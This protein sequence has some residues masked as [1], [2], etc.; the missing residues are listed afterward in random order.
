MKSLQADLDLINFLLE[1][2]IAV[3]Q[4]H[5]LLL[6]DH[7]FV[8]EISHTLVD[9]LQLI[10]FVDQH[11][12]FFDPLAVKLIATFFQII[13]FSKQVDELILIRVL[14]LIISLAH[15]FVMQLIEPAH[16]MLLFLI[17][18]VTLFDLY[19]VGDDEVLLVILLGQCLLSLFLKQFNLRLSVQLIN[20]DT[21]DFVQNIF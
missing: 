3:I 21:C 8:L 11:S 18:V 13:T 2:S 6:H 1:C 9:L 5:L 16:L 17:D 10:V 4:T 14:A 7:L 19:L 15:K 20:A 12:L